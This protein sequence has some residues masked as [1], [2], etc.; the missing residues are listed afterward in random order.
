MSAFQPAICWVKSHNFYGEHFS[1]R[2]EY[3][4]KSII[5]LIIFVQILYCS[6]QHACTHRRTDLFVQHL[7]WAKVFANPLFLI[8]IQIN[9]PISRIESIIHKLFYFKHTH[10]N[11]HTRTNTPTQCFQSAKQFNHMP[12]LKR[13]RVSLSEWMSRRNV[14][15]TGSERPKPRQKKLLEHFVLDFMTHFDCFSYIFRLR[16]GE[17]LSKLFIPWHVLWFLRSFQP[18]LLFSIL[19]FLPFFFLK[20]ILFSAKILRS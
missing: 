18:L 15:E 6:L 19:A 11:I 1:S 9:E 16:I 3:E 10:T 5:Q 17:L 12:E 14:R 7:A 2:C 20:R 4:K 8:I 13:K